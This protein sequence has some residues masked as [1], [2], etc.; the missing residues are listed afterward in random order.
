VQAGGAALSGDKLSHQ[1]RLVMAGG[2][3]AALG[4]AGL[5]AAFPRAVSWSIAAVVGVAGVSGLVRA[6]RHPDRKARRRARRSGLRRR[7]PS[8]NEHP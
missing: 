4:V 7:G 2:G 1:E 6:F 3:A 8:S 5:A